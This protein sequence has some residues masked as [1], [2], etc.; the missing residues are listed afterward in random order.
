MHVSVLLERPGFSPHSVVGAS[1]CFSVFSPANPWLVT[2]GGPEKMDFLLRTL[3]WLSLHLQG[4]SIRPCPS[5]PAQCSNPARTNREIKDETWWKRVAVVS[6]MWAAEET[7]DGSGN[8][9]WR[10]DRILISTWPLLHFLEHDGV[11]Y[12]EGRWDRWKKTSLSATPAV[13]LLIQPLM[14]LSASCVLKG[15]THLRPVHVTSCR[16]I[17]LH[18]NHWTQ[19]QNEWR[20]CVF[21]YS[22]TVT[23]YHDMFRIFF[24]SVKPLETSHIQ[25]NRLCFTC[26]EEKNKMT[27]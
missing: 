8:R 17:H 5:P 11:F 14:C 27:P 19:W 16:S 15:K 3:L 25:E 22:C 12:G 24:Q 9:Q 1:S 4:S 10:A 20:L 18:I 23:T 21:V 2:E 13:Y 6:R 26:V 7:G